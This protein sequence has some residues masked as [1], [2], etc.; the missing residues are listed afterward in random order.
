MATK[1]H[2]QRTEYSAPSVA[3]AVRL[4]LQQSSNS[5][6]QNVHIF[7]A[8]VIKISPTFSLHQ[9]FKMMS[10]YSDTC[11]KLLPPLIDGLVNDGLTEV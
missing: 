8:N 4:Q 11:Q 7:A 5:K 2:S 1:A 3:T 10:L 6:L 9:M